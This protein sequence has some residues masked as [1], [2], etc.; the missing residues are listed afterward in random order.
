[1]SLKKQDIFDE[2]PLRRTDGSKSEVWF[3]SG[4]IRCIWR[5]KTKI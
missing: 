1:M 4:L 3:I 5:K 2:E